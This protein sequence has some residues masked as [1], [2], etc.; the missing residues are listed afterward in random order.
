MRYSGRCPGG[1]LRVRFGYTCESVRQSVN[2]QVVN[3]Q[4]APSGGGR[5]M[6]RSR[7]DQ[8]ARFHRKREE[9]EQ[10]AKKLPTEEEPELPPPVEPIQ[11]DTEKVGRNDPCPCGSGKKYKKCCGKKKS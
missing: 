8:E 5:M 11:S 7:E 2:S 4:G 9:E 10:H 1:E 6:A 3:A